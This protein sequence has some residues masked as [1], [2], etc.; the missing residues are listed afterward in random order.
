MDL[1]IRDVSVGFR[2]HY[3]YEQAVAEAESIATEI[4]AVF[5]CPSIRVG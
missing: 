2:S 4:R 5:R 1:L 3:Q